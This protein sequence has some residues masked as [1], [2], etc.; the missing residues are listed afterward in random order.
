MSGSAEFAESQRGVA[1]HQRVSVRQSLA[2]RAD[3]IILVLFGCDSAERPDG[4]LANRCIR[5]AQGFLECSADN[6]CRLVLLDERQSAQI[7]ES[8]G[9]TSAHQRIGIAS[10]NFQ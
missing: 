7:A 6:G 1:P 10:Q 5:V 9:R 4:V 3:G 8:K 2:E